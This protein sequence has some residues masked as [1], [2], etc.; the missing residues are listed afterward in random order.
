MQRYQTIVFEYRGEN[1]TAN[2]APLDGVV[3][4]SD[5]LNINPSKRCYIKPISCQMSTRIPNVYSYGSFNNTLIRVKRN[6]ADAWTNI[7]LTAG[8]YLTTAEITAAITGAIASWYTNPLLPALDINANTVTDQVYITLDSSRLAGGGTQMCVDLS[9]SQIAYTLGF[10]AASTYIADGLYT[11][12]NIVHMDIQGTYCDVVCS[13]TNARMVN[14]QSRKILFSVPLTSMSGLT[15]FM[16]PVNGNNVPLIQYTGS[17]YICN[18][19]MEFK[20]QNNT[21]MVWM[22]G[23]KVQVIFEFEQEL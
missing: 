7:N 20:T 10:P 13:L 14:G 19:T 9:Q 18:Y 4:L 3:A 8:V 1:T 6:V 15:E 17:N 5:A 12:T 2:V 11:S 23:S 21:P 16:Y 22:S